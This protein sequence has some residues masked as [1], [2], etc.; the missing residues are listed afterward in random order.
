MTRAALVLLFAAL[1]A[2]GQELPWKKPAAL[3]PGDT[4]AF[5]APA[6]AVGNDLSRLQSY[7][8]QLEAA[9]YKVK[10]TPGV[11]ARRLRY[12]AGTD[13]ERA[14]EVNAAFRDP[15]VRGVFAVRG[16]YGLTRIIDKLDYD[17]L[18][19]DP[20][21]VTGFSDL[22][23]LH[24][25][26]A[27]KAR[28]VTFHSPLV[29]TSLDKTTPDVA[30]ANDAFGR[31]VFADR[32]PKGEAGYP[33][34]V[35]D[36][37]PKPAKLVGGKARGRLVGG[38]LSL[39]IATL[40]TP[41]AVQP[42]GNILFL[43]DVHEAPYRID[44][45]LSQLR[46][47]G[48]LD[49][50]AGVALGQF[51]D[52]KSNDPGTTDQV[53]D[54]YFGKLKVPVLKN[55]PMGHVPANATFPH[56][57]VADLDA[58][59]GTLRLVENPVADVTAGPKSAAD[60]PAVT[61]KGWA[62]ADGK[63]G[64]VLW[65][66]ADTTRRPMA[67]T[68]KIMTA[69]LV[70]GLAS[71][72]PKVMDEVVTFS[73]RADK[74][75][76]STAGLKAGEKVPV[77]EL[78]Y[79]MML[80]SGNDATVAFA[81]HFGKRFPQTDP[82]TDDPVARFVAE[83]DRRAVALGLT[84]TTYRDTSGLTRENQ[85]TPRDLV[86]LAWHGF[87]NE[88]FRAVVKT[89]SY[90]CDVSGTDGKPRAVTWKNTNKLL[91]DA[92]FDGVKTGTTN[93]AGACLVASG[94]KDGDH[95]F[96][97]VLGSA[98]S[99]D[100]YKDA[101]ALFDWAWAQRAKSAAKPLAGAVIV[102]DP[103]HGGQGYSRSY[104]GG[105]RGANSKLT[106]SELNL[107]VGFALAGELERL[108]ATVHHTRRA[109]HRLSR[110]GSAKGDELRARIDFFD[111]HNPHFFLSV[112]HNAGPAAA[113]GHTALYKHNAADDTLY[114]A[115]ARDVNDALAD[116]VPGP[117]RKL[118]KGEYAI[119]GGTPIPGT[120]SEAGFMTNPAF[121]ESCNLP[122]FPKR[123]A[124]ALARGAVKYWTDH[125]PALVALREKLAAERAAKPRDPATFTATALNPKYQAEMAALLAK[126]APGGKL[127]VA[128]FRAAVV[129]D[130]AAT[131]DVTAA[132]D[133]PRATLSG[134]TSD[135]AA[136]DRL[137]DV[138]VALGITDIAD[139]IKLPAAAGATRP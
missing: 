1:P 91:D 110:E 88:A 3:K 93:A 47:A 66:K 101:R 87:Q 118:I 58:D 127:D 111:H 122:D 28:V 138:L 135:R 48:V 94:R 108:G 79:G 27:A 133:G 99:D 20:K 46:L 71:S 113:T 112:H 12:L 70:L 85:S 134:A 92:G 23:A 128:A 59:A 96:V 78:M 5:V 19:A 43:E 73:E 125:K 11:E 36:A 103:G 137:I 126:A 117:K 72:D 114:E 57:A 69:L 102:V 60:A 34:P 54:E 129:T 37:G 106:E 26:C 105:T 89:P 81:E 38:N 44:R 116:A 119:L 53:L 84:D 61:A 29:L 4:I 30:F 51:T 55:F 16:G 15:A 132:I 9:G 115:L 97:V 8:K 33:I 39:V 109:N 52:D 49:Q 74:T 90:N 139:G 82:P 42:K 130:P 107:R 131:F 14:A 76:G 95:L 45:Y 86:K 24:L 83:M 63:T 120:I 22:T 2:A 18:R 40:G 25:A 67:S 100:R 68:T 35:P 7:A 104:T 50:V 64:E 121:D 10:I 75:P 62:V 80:P 136:R 13:D 32:Y 21:V 65:G 98:A 123:E 124:E 77:R 6:G 56:G 41:Y 31:A 17:A